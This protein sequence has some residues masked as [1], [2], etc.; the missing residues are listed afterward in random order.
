MAVIFPL[1]FGLIL[2]DIAY[3]LILLC[4]SL[5]ARK[6]WKHN[7]IVSDIMVMAIWCS[8][9]SIL[10][11]IIFGE[12]LG[13]LGHR[14]GAVPIHIGSIRILPV[15]K[16]RE[17]AIGELLIITIIIGLCH[18]ML[19]LVLGMVESIRMKAKHHF[20]ENMGLTLGLIS[21]L[22]FVLPI[23]VAVISETI[24]TTTASVMLL[25]SLG[26]LIKYSGIT[27][28]IEIISL[29]ANVLSYCRLMALGVAGMVIA[30]LANDL[31]SQQSNIVLGI[32]IAIPIHALAIALGILEPT[33]HALRLHFVEFLP[34][35]FI[36][37]GRTYKPLQR[38][39]KSND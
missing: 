18:V 5:W 7:L 19:G 1:F 8:S 14:V 26:I 30:N 17:D 13:D 36:G 9:A 16:A 15:W 21:I 35:F 39:D 4:L 22:L 23:P 28:P 3:G 11:G 20:W 34:K 10:F 37:D 29:C 38:K 6:K 25:A 27:G 12:F 33:I 32:M 24:R 2:G 31:G